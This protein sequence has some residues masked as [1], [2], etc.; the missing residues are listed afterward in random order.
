SASRGMLEMIEILKVKRE[1]LYLLLTLTQEKNVKVSRFPLIH[2][3]ETII[4]HTNLAEFRKFLQESENEALLDRMVIIQVPYTLSYKAEA[5]I[6]KK[7]TSSTQ[8][9]REVHLDPNALNVAAAV[10]ILT[11]LQEGDDTHTDL[12]TL[13]RLYG[14]GDVEGMASSDLEKIQAKTP[15]EALSGVSPRS[16]ISALSNAINQSQARR[17]ASMEVLLA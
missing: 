5:R 1:F 15:E 9:F 13:L 14:G 8:A 6:Y 17:L 4:A 12:S 16:V 11:R 7:L 2:L 10:A 3:D